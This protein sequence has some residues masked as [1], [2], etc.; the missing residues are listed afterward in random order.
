MRSL[1]LA[2]ILGAMVPL[3]YASC[4]FKQ[5]EKDA[6]QCFDDKEGTWYPT[7]SRWKTKDCMS[8]RCQN[9][10][11]MS[12]CTVYS[13]PVQIPDDCM[14]EFDQEACEYKVFKKDDRSVSCPI[15]AGVM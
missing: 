8:C 3:L 13:Y 14:K 10:G 5:A 6:S 7:G 15:L 12:C 2:L 4:W 9:N 1:A 11:E